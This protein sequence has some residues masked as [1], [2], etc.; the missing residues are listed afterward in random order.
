MDEFGV[1]EGANFGEKSRPPAGGGGF[2]TAVGESQIN[3][4]FGESRP[5]GGSFAANGE[6]WRIGG[7]LQAIGESK[8]FCIAGAFFVDFGVESRTAGA[9]RA[10]NLRPR[11][12][13]TTFLL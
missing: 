1:C 4:D 8:V 12:E 5:F 6:L 7:F 10:L 13:A 9:D 2:R 11:S 3:C